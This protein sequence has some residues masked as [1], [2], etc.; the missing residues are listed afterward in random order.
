MFLIVLGVTR[1]LAV[2]AIAGSAAV[3]AL[4][5]ASWALVTRVRLVALRR[6]AARE[7]DGGGSSDAGLGDSRSMHRAV[8]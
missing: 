4:V 2:S 7:R 1:D 8:M 6:A 5:F 3:V